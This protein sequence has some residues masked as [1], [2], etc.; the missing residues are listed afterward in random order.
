MSINLK[1]EID[2]ADG[3]GTITFFEKTGAYS[4]G[5]TGGWGAPNP[6]TPTATSAK[7]YITVPGATTP[8]II[9][10]FPTF[11]TTNTTTPFV[12]TPALLGYGSATS[13][14]DG[15]YVI[16]YV[17]NGFIVVFDIEFPYSFTTS[18]TFFIDCAAQ[19]CVDKMF[20]ALDPCGCKCGD[21][22]L[23]QAFWAEAL[24]EQAEKAA[25]CGQTDNAT[26]LLAQVN[27][28]CKGNCPTC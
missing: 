23:M 17:V 26:T 28:I 3:C 6:G 7:L 12:I 5:N 8:I 15:I 4:G 13:L 2:V 10:I 27:K 11:P 9:N 22:K 16:Q 14:P 25:C 20:L 18:E 19:C 1:I 24:L 21:D